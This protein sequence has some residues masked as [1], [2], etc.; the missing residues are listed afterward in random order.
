[1]LGL[2]SCFCFASLVGAAVGVAIMAPTVQAIRVLLLA[3]NSLMV[4][5]LVILEVASVV[6]LAMSLVVL[7]ALTLVSWPVSRVSMRQ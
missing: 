1:M 6:L 4:S 7:M 5:T 2:S 3:T